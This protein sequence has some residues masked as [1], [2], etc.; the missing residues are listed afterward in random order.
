MSVRHI[1]SLFLTLGKICAI[2]L[3]LRTFLV[4][5]VG[6]QPI[7]WRSLAHIFIS[8]LFYCRLD[9]KQSAI[10]NLKTGLNWTGQG[11]AVANASRM[12]LRYCIT[13]LAFQTCGHSHKTDRTI[14]LPLVI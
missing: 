9:L 10:S 12:G 7:G 5:D 4:T 8:F 13:G 2:G 3:G 11:R 1:F 14:N 6:T